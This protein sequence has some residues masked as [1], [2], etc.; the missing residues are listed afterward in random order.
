MPLS[1]MDG[2]SWIPTLTNRD[3]NLPD[4]LWVSTTSV[5]GGNSNSMMTTVISIHN[6]RIVF[7]III[8]IFSSVLSL[9]LVPAPSSS[10]SPTQPSSASS[11]Q[12]LHTPR[13]RVSSR[14]R[15]RSNSA[16]ALGLYVTVAA[17]PIRKDEWCYKKKEFAHQSSLA[18]CVCV[19]VRLFAFS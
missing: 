18:V 14:R 8:T 16:L 5:S 13:L 10:P 2:D 17:Q 15:K 12:P 19:C 1:Q 11:W 7:P 6:C 3:S 9:F 4:L